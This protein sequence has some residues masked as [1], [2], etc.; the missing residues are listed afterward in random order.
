MMGDGSSEGLVT[1]QTRALFVFMFALKVFVDMTVLGLE[2]VLRLLEE[3][4]RC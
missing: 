4:C 1:D 2:L 3:E